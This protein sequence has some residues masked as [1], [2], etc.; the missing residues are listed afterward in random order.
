MRQLS[1]Q[2]LIGRTRCPTERLDHGLRSGSLGF[3]AGLRDYEEWHRS[4]DDPGSGLSWR[5]RRVQA[6]V[7][8]A[9]DQRSGPVRLLSACSGDGRDVIGV[10]A[11]RPDADRVR[12]VLLELHPGI[13]DRARAAAAAT[14]LAGVEVRTV[15]A[16]TT[17]AYAGAVPADVVLLVGIFGNISDEDLGRTIH[18]APQLCAPGATLLWSR[19]RDERD[20]NA[21]VRAQFTAAGFAE[22]AYETLNRDRTPALGVVRY[23]GPPVDLVPGQRLFTFCR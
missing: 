6:H 3:M 10:L 12:A 22:L 18:A 23:T 19:A 13:A 20:L 4:Y 16:G 21:E 7:S 17:D 5:L 8:D 2:R 11:G 15:D 1:A 14:G 9:L